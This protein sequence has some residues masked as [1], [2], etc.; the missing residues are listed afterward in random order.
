MGLLDLNIPK[1]RKYVKSTIVQ[2]HI[3]D[4]IT[5]HKTELTLVDYIKNTFAEGFSKNLELRETKFVGI[6]DNEYTYPD[7]LGLGL[8]VIG[9]VDFMDG[10]PKGKGFIP[11]GNH[12]KGFTKNMTTTKYMKD[13]ILQSVNN[14]NILNSDYQ[15]DNKDWIPNTLSITT[16]HSRRFKAPTPGTFELNSYRKYP[17]IYNLGPLDHLGLSIKD[18]ELVDK[19]VEHLGDSFTSYEDLMKN[20]KQPYDFEWGISPFGRAVAQRLPGLR[21]ISDLALLM[22][23]LRNFKKDPKLLLSRQAL[24]QLTNPNPSTKLLNPFSIS[25]GGIGGPDTGGRA[26]FFKQTRFL[27]ITSLK[28][29]FVDTLSELTG[30]SSSKYGVYERFEGYDWNR[31]DYIGSD[32]KFSLDSIQG[33]MGQEGLS[34]EGRRNKGNKLY[35][36]AITRFESQKGDIGIP[37]TET[38]KEMSFGGMIWGAVKDFATDTFQTQVIDKA[39]NMRDSAMMAITGQRSGLPSPPKQYVK[40]QRK[41]GKDGEKI[42]VGEDSKGNIFATLDYDKL[43]ESFSY[44]KTLQSAGE[45]QIMEDFGARGIH[46]NKS[47]APDWYSRSVSEKVVGDIGSQGMLA[48]LSNTFTDPDLG[49]TSTRSSGKID[50][51]NAHPY[52]RVLPEDRTPSYSDFIPFR[53]KDVVNEKYLVFRAILSGINDNITPEWNPEKY[54][55]RA[56]KV[57]VYT[58]AERNISFTFSIAPKSKYELPFLIDKLNHLIGLCYPEYDKAGMGNGRMIAPFIELTIGNILDGAPGFLNSL[59]YTVEESSP[60]EIMDG[61]QFP[62]YII[63]SCDF[64]YIGNELPSKYGQHFGTNTRHWKST[65]LNDNYMS[66]TSWKPTVYEPDEISDAIFSGEGLFNPYR[67]DFKT[68][69]EPPSA[70]ALIAKKTGQLTEEDVDRLRSISNPIPDWA[71]GD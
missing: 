55:G 21:M 2:R 35:Q 56:D 5:V 53:F 36:W 7:T 41:L 23:G 31:E 39:E 33:L 19:Y 59:S 46:D 8:G 18:S 68:W 34:K 66:D 43:R 11:P 40:S 37:P 58:G 45:S 69:K 67:K 65:T 62:K 42:N 52:G 32:G 14:I 44:E 6:S 15:L 47:S 57:Y 70:A 54:I 60:W 29:A 30:R 71:F 17:K 49:K 24:A 51:I 3:S 26:V 10:I 9:S 61:L 22:D 28:D 13:G 16:H 20:T 48:T 4:P 50:K 27:N 12:P 1:L 25:T 63:V 38:K 64:R